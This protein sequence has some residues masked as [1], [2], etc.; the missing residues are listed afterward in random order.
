MADQPAGGEARA[1]VLAW[2]R[3]VLVAM[4]GG[5]FVHAERGVKRGESTVECLYI[6]VFV[7]KI[8]II[9]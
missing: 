4:R 5:G 3:S 9:K 6:Y 7:L 1:A 8:I 2:V